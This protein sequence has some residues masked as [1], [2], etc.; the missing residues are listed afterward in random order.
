V[1]ARFELKNGHSFS[2][3]QNVPST[4]N[5]ITPSEMVSIMTTI[6]SRNQLRLE[7][8]LPWLDLVT[9]IDRALNGR[10]AERYSAFRR[11]W[12]ERVRAKSLEKIRRWKNDPSWRPTSMFQGGI[13][14][15]VVGGRLMDRLYRRHC[16]GRK[17]KRAGAGR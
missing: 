13:E 14:L 7:A 2:F 4:H 5:D 3:G 8:R 9:E 17:L 12:E 6:A 16:G 10:E 1:T 11:E 15:E